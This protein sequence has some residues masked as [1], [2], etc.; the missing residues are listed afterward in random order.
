MSSYDTVNLQTDLNPFCPN[1]SRAW[2]SSIS[3]EDLENYDRTINER[4][5]E[6][7]AYA[8]VLGRNTRRKL[9]HIK[10]MAEQILRSFHLRVLAS[11][12]LHRFLLTNILQV[13]YSST[14]PTHA[15]YARTWAVAG[16]FSKDIIN[17]LSSRIARDSSIFILRSLRQSLDTILT[18][19]TLF[20]YKT[21]LRERSQGSTQ[22][23]LLTVQIKVLERRS[24][25]SCV[26]SES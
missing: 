14:S 23:K 20:I 21:D 8:V 24:I 3:S 26:C 25:D 5:S 10:A 7:G 4:R 13:T 6:A 16:F 9:D 19:W 12:P 11:H 15:A 18:K 2:R 22:S 1:L 17:H